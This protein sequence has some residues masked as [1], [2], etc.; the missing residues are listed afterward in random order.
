[1]IEMVVAKCNIFLLFTVKIIFVVCSNYIWKNRQWKI[2]N[3]VFQV[4]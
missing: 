4:H 3:I 2:D 1:M